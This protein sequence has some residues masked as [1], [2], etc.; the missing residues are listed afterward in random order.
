ML[1]LSQQLLTSMRLRCIH[2]SLDTLQGRG[3]ISE[4][5]SMA[6]TDPFYDSA[7]LLAARS[8]LSLLN[9]PTKRPWLRLCRGSSTD[10]VVD[11]VQR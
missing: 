6:N 3:L 7:L 4:E 2:R 5:R 11:A 8:L 1:R 10:S 9:S